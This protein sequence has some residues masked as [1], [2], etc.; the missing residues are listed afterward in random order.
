MKSGQEEEIV[1]AD[2]AEGLGFGINFTP[3]LFFNG[4]FIEGQNS[5]NILLS[6]TFLSPARMHQMTNFFYC[7]SLLK[8]LQYFND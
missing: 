6:N 7:R 4:H 5:S 1:D 8:R 3:A 2:V